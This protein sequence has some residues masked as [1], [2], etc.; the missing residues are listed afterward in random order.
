[1][2]VNELD[3]LCQL[4]CISKT[5]LVNDISKALKNQRPFSTLTIDKVELKI[6]LNKKNMWFEEYVVV[7]YIGGSIAT[8]RNTC[9]SVGYTFKNIGKLI[10]G[11]YYD[12]VDEYK[13]LCKDESWELV[14]VP[15]TEIN[16]DFENENSLDKLVALRNLVNE[17]INKINENR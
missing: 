10:N 2:K 12:E 4:D 17:R 5:K 8:I 3:D 16:N 1:M 13:K 6:F 11:G 7:T 15:D 14:E 9:N